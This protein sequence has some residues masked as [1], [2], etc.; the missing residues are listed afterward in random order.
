MKLLFEAY[1]YQQKDVKEFCNSN[2]ESLFAIT[3]GNTAVFN[4]VGYFYSETLNDAIFI[5]PKVL[6]T[7][8]ENG[9]S[10]AFGKFKPESFIDFDNL[11]ATPDT[12]APNNAEKEFI[13][14]L[15]V[16]LY[17]AINQYSIR[18]WQNQSVDFDKI[19]EIS[20]SRNNEEPNTRTYL[21]IILQLFRF[22][23]EHSSLFTFI[24]LTHSGGNTHINWNKTINKKQPLILNGLPYYHEFITN[25]KNVNY[26]EQL[27]VLFY[28]VLIYLRERYHFHVLMP[29]NYKLISPNKIAS[30]LETGKGTRLLRSIRKNYF[31]D[32]LVSLW[33]LLYVFFD[34]SE[35]ISSRRY[36]AERLVVR[37][38]NNVFEDMI[39]KL[40]SD[41][42]EK[43]PEKLRSQADGK[44]V[45]HIYVDESLTGSEEVY[46]IGDSKYYQDK[47][48]VGSTS[49][50]KQ[51]TYA[52]N[53][54]QFNVGVLDGKTEEER[55]RYRDS[56]TE[57]YNL[58]PNFFIRGKLNFDEL[59]AENHQLSRPDDPKDQEH[60]MF[61]FKNRLFDRD[62]LLIQTYNIN[63]LYVMNAY[64]SRG[65]NEVF[66]KEARER[67]R[68]DILSRL[69]AKYVFYLVECQDMSQVEKF[70]N[71]NFRN[72]IGK[73]YR[74]SE[75]S[76]DILLAFD[77]DKP[78]ENNI[79]EIQKTCGLNCR[80]V[81][82]PIEDK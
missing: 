64:I 63:F 52:K 19:S 37:K 59:T 60:T 15:A 25:T 74:I 78:E 44:I 12:P 79:R 9:A 8:N 20:T 1:P 72:L 23:K 33:K 21:D 73:M 27:I 58:T 14:R 45:D 7:E 42:S 81:I 67:F 55:L 24:S 34:K 43:I 57:G 65:G 77:K 47:N 22:H 11:T 28:S 76:T 36:H 17:Q 13:S 66:R 40:L 51:F 18:Q 31:K 62:T 38:F 39:D 48:D 29:L 16:W 3:P 75:N 70:V 35:M 2:G 4:C 56:K 41:T 10:L 32:E 6:I 46:Y 50:Y 5:L 68:K 54:V 71:D 82:L 69:N 30:M 61:Q 49:V 26:D 53:V 80:Q